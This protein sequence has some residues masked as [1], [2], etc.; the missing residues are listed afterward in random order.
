MSTKVGK[1]GVKINSSSFLAVWLLGW[2]TSEFFSRAGSLPRR[3]KLIWPPP[4]AILA[5][6]GLFSSNYSDTTTTTTSLN[7]Q[8]QLCRV[9]ICGRDPRAVKVLASVL[10]LTL[11]AKPAICQWHWQPTVTIWG[12]CTFFV[13]RRGICIL[14]KISRKQLN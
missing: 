10:S 13:G 1:Y 3:P 9:F 12:K 14:Y 7:F 5:D 4:A 8:Q 11:D 2:G 6:I